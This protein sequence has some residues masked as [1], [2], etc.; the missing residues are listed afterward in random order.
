MTHDVIYSSVFVR[1]VILTG[2]KAEKLLFSNGAGA[3]REQRCV[4]MAAD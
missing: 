2:C 4:G 1:A 3:R